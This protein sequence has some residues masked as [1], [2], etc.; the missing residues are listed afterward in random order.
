MVSKRHERH[1]GQAG[2][3]IAAARVAAATQGP[4][5]QVFRRRRAGAGA[6]RIQLHFL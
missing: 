4:R 6:E 2:V 5:V 3:S 1:S